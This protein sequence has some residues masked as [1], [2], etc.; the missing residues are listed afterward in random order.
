[1][2]NVFNIV[3]N[4]LNTRKQIAQNFALNPD[5]SIMITKKQK[6]HSILVVRYTV[7]ELL[8]LSA[9]LTFVFQNFTLFESYK[10]VENNN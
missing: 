7:N 4:F 8:L 10:K 6:N 5:S 2:F 1:M 3:R 9:H